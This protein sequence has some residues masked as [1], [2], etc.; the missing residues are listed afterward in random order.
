MPAHNH[1]ANPYVIFVRRGCYY[2]KLS[3]DKPFVYLIGEDR[4]NTVL[5]YDDVASGVCA[6]TPS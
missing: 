5:F 3:I 4:E 2:E 6:D 1:N